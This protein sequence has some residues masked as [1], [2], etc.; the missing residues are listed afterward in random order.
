MVH[1]SCNLVLWL[2]IYLIV[3]ASLPLIK[4]IATICHV[5]ANQVDRAPKHKLRFTKN[6]LFVCT[7]KLLKQSYRHRRRYTMS[8]IHKVMI[9]AILEPP[10]FKG[11][12]V[13]HIHDRI[14]I[15]VVVPL[16]FSL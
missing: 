12:N 2:L 11:D 10:G 13:G 4:V 9:P 3:R 16:V 14:I 7:V 1:L 15:M 6:L 8:E 5:A